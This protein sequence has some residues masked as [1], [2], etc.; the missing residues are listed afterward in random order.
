MKQINP[1]HILFFLLTLAAIL[2]PVW[3]LPQISTWF[4]NLNQNQ[5]DV[6]GALF[7]A[8]PALLLFLGNVIYNHSERVYFW[9]N[10]TTLWFSNK[11]VSWTIFVELE[12]ERKSGVIEEIKTNLIKLYPDTKIWTDDNFKKTFKIP[13]PI[14][15]NLMVKEFNLENDDGLELTQIA[16]EV[17]DFVVPFRHSLRSIRDMAALLN[18]CVIETAS[19]LV[20][21]KFTFKINFEDHNPYFGLFVKQLRVPQKQLVHFDCIFNDEVGP[22][23]G[24]IQVSSNKLSL[25][26]DSL[27]NLQIL[28]ERYI[29]LATLDLTS[30]SG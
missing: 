1:K 19:N 5:L 26:T 14:A 23:N 12:Q 8:T 27:A 20:K 17:S 2:L 30:S 24:T 11:S 16:I 29:T 9:V 22:A 3:A 13:Y 21:S 18:R 6:V 25:T 10:R 7:A 15:A 4:P 28:S